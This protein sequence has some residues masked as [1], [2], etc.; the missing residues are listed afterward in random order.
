MV[1][2]FTRFYDGIYERLV[3]ETV[4]STRDRGQAEDAVQEALIIVLG[5]WQSIEH[6][7]RYVRTVLRNLV[8]K[9]ASERP[10]LVPVDVFAGPEALERDVAD[11]VELRLALVAVLHELPVQQQR[12]TALH[13]L[14]DKSVDQV[15]EDLGVTESTVR[16]HLMQ[17]RRRIHDHWE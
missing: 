14:V 5:R 9:K 17:A 16:V 6:P 1:E 10:A 15:A 7:E 13:Y 2:E 4:R 8:A 11:G 12:A 3:R